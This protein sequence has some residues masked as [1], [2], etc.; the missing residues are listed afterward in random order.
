MDPRGHLVT[1]AGFSRKDAGKRPELRVLSFEL[2]AEA[3]VGQTKPAD[4]LAKP[5]CY[6][7]LKLSRIPPRAS[8]QTSEKKKRT[9]QREDLKI[10][11]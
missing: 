4:N 7:E 8:K 9:D 5:V 3:Q 11:F 1:V 10:G 6:K 2:L